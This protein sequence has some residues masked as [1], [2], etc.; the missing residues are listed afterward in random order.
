MGCSQTDSAKGCQGDPGHQAHSRWPGSAARRG[1]GEPE[2]DATRAAARDPTGPGQIGRRQWPI[3][4]QKPRGQVTMGET[5]TG[6][7]KGDCQT[8]HMDPSVIKSEPL[9]S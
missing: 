7:Y 5:M 8:G 6:A 2:V 4:Q 1:D 3:V 9:Q